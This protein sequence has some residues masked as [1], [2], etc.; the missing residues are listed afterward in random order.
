MNLLD[1]KGLNFLEIEVT[2]ILCGFLLGVDLSKIEIVLIVAEV[3]NAIVN[4][5]GIVGDRAVPVRF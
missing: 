1:A 2:D 4:V 5:S 3:R